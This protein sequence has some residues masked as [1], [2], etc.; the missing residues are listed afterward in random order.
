[1]DAQ[2]EA[3]EF[4]AA[5]KQDIQE[6]WKTLRDKEYLR[7]TNYSKTSLSERMVKVKEC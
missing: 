2:I 6:K 7:Q 5:M 3:I 1:M 4:A